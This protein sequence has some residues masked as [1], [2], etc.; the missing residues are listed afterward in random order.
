MKQLVTINLST[1][2]ATDWTP[3]EVAFGE[4]LTLALRFRKNSGGNDVEAPITVTALTAALGRVD[5]RPTG[6]K[7][8]LKIGPGAI[9][10]TNVTAEIDLD[11]DL[12]VGKLAD[13]INAVAAAAEYG[14]AKVVD[15]E[16]SWLILFG[17]QD[18]EVTIEVVKNTLWPISYGLVRA[19]Q[20]DGKW[21]HE[22][23]LIQAPC[24]LTST[25]ETV[26]P[27]APVITRIQAGG[28]LDL[29]EWNEIQQL[30]IPA[31]FRGSYIIKRGYLKTQPLSRENT[32]EE[33]LE[34]MQALGAGDFKVTL[35]LSNKPTIEFIGDLAGASQDLLVAE[36]KQSPI[37]DA[38]FSLE[39]DRAE[40]AA[41]LRPN[42][43]VTLPLE[44]RITGT[45]GDIDTK[46]AITL[47][48]TVRPPLV[49]P[50]IEGIPTVELLRPYSAETYVPYGA[51]N[52]LTAGRAYQ[53]TVGDGEVAEFVIAHGLASEAV[54]VFVR[55][56]VSGGRLLVNGTDFEVAIDSNNQ[57]TVIALLDPPATNGW[58]IVVLSA[59]AVAQWAT[60]LTVTVPQV[61]AG[62]GYPALPDFMDDMDERLAVVETLLSVPGAGS[63]AA[64]ETTKPNAIGLIPLAEALPATVVRGTKDAPIYQLPPLP[65]GIR[66]ASVADI[67]GDE[68]ADPTTQ[69]GAVLKWNATSEVYLTPGSRRGRLI[70][71]ADA[72]AVLCDGYN[73][74]L[75]ADKSG[76]VTGPT[77]HPIEM[78]RTLWEIALTP[79]LLAPGRKLTVSF[80]VLLALVAQR[81][82]LRGVY[83]L[84]VRKGTMT[85]ESS[86]T[87]ANVE[88]VV[89]DQADGAEQ[90]LF[91]QR[92]SLTRALIVHPFSVV[93]SRDAA[94]DL[95]ATRTAYGKTVSS[96][97]PQNTQFVLRA[98][99][100]RFDLENYT[101]ALGLP[102]GQVIAICGKAENA[103]ALMKQFDFGEKPTPLLAAAIS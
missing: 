11:A 23:R 56:N 39:L 30:Y 95:S 93:I 18:A 67:S 7:F 49:W 58:R 98:E 84:R 61:V 41:R 79:E 27:P 6:G 55:E 88:A 8:A 60:D 10:S 35:P 24:A 34:A 26:L 4:T 17:E 1:R 100:C 78:D 32:L 72:P 9:T 91:E 94:G 16:G 77:F 69:A 45:E 52:S 73:W 65:R 99:L 62:S 71:T 5:Q 82:E 40:L 92:I 13:A 64:E 46:L 50:V 21:L 47:P 3:P 68:L 59:I 14:A 80:S 83:T 75:A 38:T 66:D 22:L 57:V 103:D 90:V 102:L 43:P 44:I 85:S 97:A 96:T 48:V 33:I 53:A 70:T 86:M 25:V 51:G 76:A 29:A 101:N 87:G 20:V 12:D 89:W 42:V 15:V 37:G 81:P 74:W 54:M 28:S 31:E 36:V 2:T 19:W 63:T